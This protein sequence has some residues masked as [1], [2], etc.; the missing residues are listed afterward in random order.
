MSYGFVKPDCPESADTEI[1]DIKEDSKE[2]SN[3]DLKKDS[4]DVASLKRKQPQE[5]GID[6][7][8][9]SCLFNLI[10]PFVSITY[11]N[12]GLKSS[13]LNAKSVEK[14]FLIINVLSIIKAPKNS[15]NLIIIINNLFIF[16]VWTRNWY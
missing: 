12:C 10:L 1:K 5:P 9:S 15:H 16:L 8:C 3:E 2:N 6:L 7:S 13:L 11:V 4:E 14:C